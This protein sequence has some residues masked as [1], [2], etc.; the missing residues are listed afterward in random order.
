VLSACL[1]PGLVPPASAADAPAAAGFEA[2]AAAQYDK[3]LAFAVAGRVG[4]VKVQPGQ[5]VEKGQL[6]MELE[7]QEGQALV[8]QYEVRAASDV[9]L[10]IAQENLVGAQIEEKHLIDLMA[11]NS[12]APVELERAVV[13]RKLAELD[14]EKA[15]QE[16]VEMGQQLEQA[17]AKHEQ[18][19]LVAPVSG[20]VEE[21][22]Y[23]ESQSV[24]PAKPVVRLVVTDPLWIDV[25]V[26][27]AA[28]LGLSVGA[29]A[30][31]HSA[32]PGYDQ[33]LPGKVILVAQVGDAASETRLIRVEVPNPTHLPA[34][35]TVT[36]DFPTVAAAAK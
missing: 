26:P 6:L 33:P 31:A 15:K 2:V 10:R 29:S 22:N 7:D 3:K 34:G 21:V 25:A 36:V 28:T 27:T 18:Y 20:V 17:R 5:H 23:Y 4:A 13:K 1:L 30:R 9:E 11:Q 16:H 32:M 35:T 8:A 24:E 12:A 14:V 19:R